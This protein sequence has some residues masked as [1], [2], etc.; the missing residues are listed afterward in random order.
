MSASE[1]VFKNQTPENCIEC[2]A[3]RARAP[4][5]GHGRGH[6]LGSWGIVLAIVALLALGAFGA[7]RFF[8]SGRFKGMALDIAA[9][10]AFDGMA[11]DIAARGAKQIKHII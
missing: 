5:S 11:L 8:G 7:G 3:S 2:F 10:A 4:A 9:L 6:A 1:S